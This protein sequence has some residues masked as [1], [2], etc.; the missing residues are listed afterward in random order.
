MDKLDGTGSSGFIIDTTKTNLYMISFGWLGI[1]PITFWVNGGAN[2]GWI[3]FHVIDLINNYVG[4][5]INNPVVPI[6]A[7]VSNG[8]TQSNVLLRSIC[9]SGGIHKAGEEDADLRKFSQDSLKT[10]NNNTNT[11]II[12]LK[13]DLTFMGSVNKVAVLI[14]SISYTTDGGNSTKPVKIYVYKDATFNGTAQYISTD[15]DSVVLYNTSSTSYKT[16]KLL[17]CIGT[18]SNGG[19]LYELSKP[20]K[21]Y[22]GET[23]SFCALCSSS[24][25]V[26]IAVNWEENF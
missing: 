20:I 17:L 16:G 25:I 11:N 19:G 21:F 3:P 2:I 7:Q 1:A 8:N 4:P 22:P 6:T 13:N 5:S 26:Q 24:N 18:I 9:W 15:S 10:V 12:T 23:V 14:N